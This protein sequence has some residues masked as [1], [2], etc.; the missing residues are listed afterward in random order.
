VRL[1]A[2]GAQ[3]IVLDLKQLEFIDS[4]GFRAILAAKDVCERHKCTFAMIRGKERVQR[5]FDVSGV[6]RKLPFVQR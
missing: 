5:L 4:T 6:L 2:D 1:C 3:E